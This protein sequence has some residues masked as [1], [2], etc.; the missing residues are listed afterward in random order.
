MPQTDPWSSLLRPAQT[1]SVWTGG[2]D[3]STANMTELGKI[4][5]RSYGTGARAVGR[6]EEAWEPALGFF[7]ALLYGDQ[8]AMNQAIGP[9]RSRIISQYDAARKQVAEFAP[10][11]GGRSELL[12]ELPFREAGE[13][14]R[15]TQEARAGAAKDLTGL[16]ALYGQLG[17]E[18][19]RLAEGA[20]ADSL[21]AALLKRQQEIAKKTDLGKGLGSLLA[22]LIGGLKG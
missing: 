19:L 6:A 7:K 10:R 4:A 13:I 2:K 16:G 3:W 21:R 18:E 22:M 20:T 5:E 14:G 8:E 15:L 11:G 17:T 12:A 9:A 1:A